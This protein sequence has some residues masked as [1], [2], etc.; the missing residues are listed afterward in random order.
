[1][2]DFPEQPS[3]E[4]P[5]ERGGWHAP[6]ESQLWQPPQSETAPRAVWRKVKALPDEMP[7][8]DETSSGTWHLPRPEDTRYDE[9]EEI[10]IQEG[11]TSATT[12]T[13]PLVLAPEDI[14]A[15]IVGQRP[16]R[17]G[18]APPPEDALPTREGEAPTEAYR[19]EDFEF[20]EHTEATRSV[21]LDDAETEA[22][23]AE[24]MA[25][26]ESLGAMDD[27][28]DQ[29]T[30]SEYIALA[31]LEQ[32]AQGGEGFG[33]DVNPEDLSPA[34]KALYNIASEAAQELPAESEPEAA[35][36]EG[37]PPQGEDAASI[38]ARMAAEYA[39]DDTQVLADTAQQAPAD[40]DAADYAARMAA[41]YGQP[42][43][44]QQQQQAQQPQYSQEELDL[45]AQF[46][47]TRHNVQVLKQMHENGQLDHQEYQR[48][49]QEQSILDP[50]GNWW[51]LGVETNKWYRFDQTQQQWVEAQPPVPLDAGTPRTLT[52]DLN[53]DDVI[54]GSLP[55]LPHDDGTQFAG[56]YSEYS[57]YDPTQYDSSQQQYAD[58]YG[59]YDTPVPNPNQPLVDPNRTMVGSAF[60]ADVLPGSEE[61]VQGFGQVY[62]DAQQTMRSPSYYGDEMEQQGEYIGTP[63][64]VEQA[65]TYEQQAESDV[66]RE[67][68][69]S[70]QRSVLTII[71]FGIFGLVVVSLI[72]AIGLGLYVMNVYESTV[73]PYREQI[74][75][76]ANYTPDFQ[77]ARIVDANGDVIVELSSEDGERVPVSILEGEVSPFFLHA[78]VSSEDPTYYE[79][80]GFN[81]LSVLRAFLQNLSAGEV[82]SGASTITQQISR[83][84]ILQ[85]TTPTAERKLTE[86]FI[87]L[88]I[89][90]TYTK[91]EILDIYINEFFFGNQSYGVEAASQFY[92]DQPASELNM[93]QSAMLVGI[94]PSPSATNPV[95]NREAAFNNMNRVIDSM[96]ETGCLNFQH[97]QWAEPGELFCVNENTFVIDPATGEQVRLFR[98]LDDGSYGEGELSVQRALVEAG[99]YEPRSGDLAYPHF[100]T[101]VV[102]QIEAI[103]GPGA[104]YQRGFTVYTTIIPRLQDAAEQ[105]LQDGVG[106]NSLNG[107]ETGAVI[108]IDPT[109]G[110]IRALVGSPDFDN[111]DIDGQV[112]N[113]RT[114]QQPGSAIKPVLYTAALSGAAPSGY[115]TPASILWDVPSSYRVG[116]TIY[117]PRNFDGQYRGPVPVRFALQQSLNIPAVKAYAFVGQDTFVNTA[118]ILGINFL[119]DTTFGLPSALGANEVR[120]IDLAHSYA[121]LANDGVYTPVFAIE[122]IEDSAGATVT[123]PERGEPR[124][125]ITPQLAYVMQNILS[126]DSARAP[127]FGANTVLSGAS[128]GLPNQGRVAAKTGTTDDQNDLWTVGF[129]N[130]WV[131]GVWMGTVLDSTTTSGNLTGFRVA[132]PVWNEVMTAALAGRD[133]GEFAL[134]P[135]GIRQDAVCQLTGTLSAGSGCPQQV[136]E[137]YIADQPPPPPSEGIVQTIPIDSWTGLRAN[138]W[139]QMNVIER[140]Y[141]DI[142]DPF[143][144]N[145]LNTT[146]QGQQYLR[147]L[148]LPTPLE[149]PPEGECQQGQV[150]PTI[151]IANPSEN[152]THQGEL[153][154]TGQVSVPGT[155][156]LSR[157]ELQLAPVNT[158]NFNP[159]TDART[160]QVPNNGTE[161]ARIDTRLYDNGT[162]VLRLAA[163]SAVGGFIYEDVTINIDNPDPTATP[164]PPPTATPANTIAPLPFDDPTATPTLDPLG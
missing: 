129:T 163:F 61:T 87:A 96:I 81:I 79:N 66:Y 125:V 105:A 134:P 9:D 13:T 113:T 97:G 145:W 111:P 22:F 56:E 75:T 138:Q 77:T 15:E 42:Q 51:M 123:L 29:F 85:D 58:Q 100:V 139:C 104:L 149:S 82:V 117:E 141:A 20:P 40:S 142:G 156:A 17:T 154:I 143:A 62:G 140:T 146:P 161:L 14:L 63:T 119:E 49:L 71:A 78:L 65:P 108:V 23:D 128:F 115:L 33:D 45:A 38:A 52:D 160:D 7:S 26:L 60:D 18:S 64:P 57:Q 43:E 90:N 10:T 25:G 101:Y 3:Q 48:R 155:P 133:P 102:G 2:S 130:N 150:L 153:V 110:A 109:T 137:I 6:Q 147:L 157:W 12:G 159:I 28:D 83:N 70:Q 152:S 39:G 59:G 158:Q 148:G 124:Q 122:R 50:Q 34:E 44:F 120:L 121:T 30:M 69:A 107:I 89:A 19:P 74:A 32:G 21:A 37:A 72:A 114:Y 41:Q 5:T 127:Q 91:N 11:K 136:V 103:F 86:I 1:M 112:D 126:D 54:A 80:P 84:L 4:Q 132:A 8:E 116:D 55:Q 67:T 151:G 16:R 94:L 92:F 47:E 95:T 73:A 106:A 118:E 99:N 53:P 135:S 35:A 144:V 31:S 36:G 131:V 24:G 46:R 164:T 98:I 68:R 76:L 88:E 93:A 162:Y 27:D